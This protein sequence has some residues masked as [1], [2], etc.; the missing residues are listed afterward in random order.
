LGGFWEITT[1]S[2]IDW[3]S[4]VRAVEIL[5]HNDGQVEIVCTLLDHGAPADSLA[6]LHW[7][8]ARLFAGTQVASMQGRP[9]DGHV[10]LLL[11]RI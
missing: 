10:R 8:L 9:E 3:P 1:A 2:L 6:G 5:R 11:P 4:Q 7:R